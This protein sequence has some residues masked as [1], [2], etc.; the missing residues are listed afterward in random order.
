M[1][2]RNSQAG[3]RAHRRRL[4]VRPDDRTRPRD[5]PRLGRLR[6][7]G[8]LPVGARAGRLPAPA[9]RACA[10]RG[11][12]VADGGRRRRRRRHDARLQVRGSWVFLYPMS[13]HSAGEWGRWTSFFFSFSVLLVGLSIVTW[14][15]AILHT[16]LGPALARGEDE[17]PQ[18]ARR[19]A[20]LRLR[21]ADPIRHQPTP[22]PVRGDPAD[23]DRDRHDHRH[24]AA[25]GRCSSR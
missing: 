8:A 11:D 24:A 16:V 5:V 2:L 20:R 7:D 17:P 9:L 10:R 22:G 21:L 13:F 25:G 6:A 12:V 14:C 19:C 18:P 3:R 4:V 15:L 23:G 1:V